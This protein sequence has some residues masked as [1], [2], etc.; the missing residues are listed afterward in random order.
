MRLDSLSRPRVLGGAP[1]RFGKGSS[2]NDR[3]VLGA[4]VDEDDLWFAGA[5]VLS[6]ERAGAE[7]CG[8]DEPN[9]KKL[10]AGSIHIVGSWG[11]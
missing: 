1:R 6:M 11:P 3:N 7:A 8:A 2:G 4:G 5:A 10:H 9:R